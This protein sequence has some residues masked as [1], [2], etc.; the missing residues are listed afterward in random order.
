M[1]KFGRKWPAILNRIISSLSKSLVTP[2]ILLFIVSNLVWELNPHSLLPNFSISELTFYVHS[3]QDW[4]GNFRFKLAVQK[5]TSVIE[6]LGCIWLFCAHLGRVPHIHVM[7]SWWKSNAYLM[8]H[9][10]FKSLAFGT[11]DGS[12]SKSTRRKLNC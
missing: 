8:W 10:L 5:N 1:V 2:C 7:W 6:F 3:N 4:N 9:E 12:W 11:F